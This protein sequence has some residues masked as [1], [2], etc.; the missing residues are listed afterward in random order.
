MTAPPDVPGVRGNGVR[1]ARADL[2]D[3]VQAEA[4]LALID[5]YARD[6]M[7]GGE[8]LPPAVRDR[9]IPGLRAHPTTLVFLAWDGT[10]AIGAAVCF[11]G[12]ST[13]AAR[14]LVN[15]H[16]L[17]V[18]PAWRGRGVGRLLLRAVA[19]WARA[20][21]CCK[22]TLEVLDHNRRARALYDSEG[23]RPPDMGHPGEQMLFLTKAL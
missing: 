2:A 7:G 9:L 11:L 18:V 1:V 4:V 10:E 14:P 21:D 15:I 22:V 6:L 17:S 3:P 5:T 16:D 8:P 13:F 20:H 23:F 12:Y 19:D